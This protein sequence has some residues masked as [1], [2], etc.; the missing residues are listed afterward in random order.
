MDVQYSFDLASWLVSDWSAQ[1]IAVKVAAVLLV[2][3]PLLNWIV[4]LTPTK[5]DNIALNMVV[6]KFARPLVQSKVNRQTLSDARL[7]PEAHYKQNQGSA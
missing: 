2:L 7:R 5:I 3:Y 4:E 6:N 1:S